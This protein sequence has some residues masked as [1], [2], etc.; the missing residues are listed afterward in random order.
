MLK[1][2][3]QINVFNLLNFSSIFKILA[4]NAQIANLLV[5]FKLCCSTKKTKSWYSCSL[6]LN[7]KNI[8]HYEN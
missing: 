8:N 2:E 3:V 4:T 6:H 1:Q 5:K 7:S